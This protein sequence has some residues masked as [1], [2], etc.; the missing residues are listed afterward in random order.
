MTGVQT[1]ALPISQSKQLIELNFSR[2]NLKAGNEYH[3][4]FSF[5]DTKKRNYSDGSV[6]IASEQ[7][8]LDLFPEP[9]I[10]KGIS[11]VSPLR[12]ERENGLTVTGKDFHIHFDKLTGAM[13]QF[14]YRGSGLLKSPL[15]PCFWR[16]P[17]DNDEGRNNSYASSWRKAG[18]DDYKIKPKQLDF[19]VL[20]KIGRAHV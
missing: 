20:P 9:F 5:Y 15:L 6:E 14:V 17:T 3:V 2:K 19:V 1:C 7:L 10:E 13:S 11:T 12:V 8:A 16:V 18:L 4:N